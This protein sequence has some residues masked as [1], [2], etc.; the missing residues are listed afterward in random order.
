M[1]NRLFELYS[2][3][4]DKLCTAMQ[5]VIE[6][7][8]V[9]PT[10]PLLLYMQGRTEGGEDYS[11]ADIR[12][13]VFGQETNGWWTSLPKTNS[14]ANIEMLI[15]KYDE[16][17]NT[18]G[19]FLLK[20]PFWKGF[21]KFRKMLGEKY[22]GK[23]IRYVWNN[24]VKI[25][26]ADGKGCTPDYIYNIEREHFSIIAEEVKIINPNVILFLTGPKY[27]N[28]IA[29]NFEQLQYSAISPF[30][31]NELAELSIPDVD[32]AFRMYHP[33]YFRYRNDISMDSFFNAIIQNI[34]F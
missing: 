10:N 6:T 3:K 31:E 28:K 23:K 18:D 4:W 25:G 8:E 22:P 29:D 30:S 21:D 13:M 15:D 12:V 1:N 24:I 16:G 14:F 33:N 9:K 11:E 19:I 7:K 26:K 27:D 34:V 5:P 20:T 32:F 17:F 2:S